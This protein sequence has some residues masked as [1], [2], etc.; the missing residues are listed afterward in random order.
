MHKNPHILSFGL[1]LGLACGSAAAQSGVTLYGIVDLAIQ[2]NRAGGVG[3]STDMV[4]GG[5]STSRIGFRGREDLGGDLYAAFHLESSVNADT[6]TGR[7]SNTNNQASGA[8]ANNGALTFDRMAFVSLG[9]VR[10]G[11]LRL[12]HDFMPHH[13]NSIL[14]EPFTA[15]GA[16]RAGNLTFSAVGTGPLFTTITG[17]NTVSYWLPKDIGG[18]YGMAILGRGENAA[19]SANRQDGNFFGGRLGFVSGPFDMAAAVTRTRYATTPTLGDYTHANLGA[20][21][22][23]GFAKFFALY[24][25]IEV[26][27]QAGDARKHTAELGVQIPITAHSRIRASYV[28]LDDRSSAVLANADGS[29]RSG[30]DAQQ[31]GAGVVHDLSKRTA[32]YGTYAKVHNRGQATYLPSGARAPLAGR[33]ASALELGIR[34]TF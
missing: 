4:S 29:Q 13:Y 23:A 15:V 32:L 11:E 9:H 7:P 21:W 14:F 25:M 31:F 1:V 2:H 33:N 24:N 28:R 17:S 16:A 34:H 22:N 19:G 20:S 5:N 18:L 10:Y 26:E 3:S 30:N 12:G 8:V 6:G 27:L